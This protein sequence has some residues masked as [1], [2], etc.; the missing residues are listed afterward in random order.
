MFLNRQ[1]IEIGFGATNVGMKQVLAYGDFKVL[2]RS[3]SKKTQM[4]PHVMPCHSLIC[5]VL[6]VLSLKF[7]CLSIRVEMSRA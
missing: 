5:Q 2:L 4:Y 1:H 3:K 7:V 6:D